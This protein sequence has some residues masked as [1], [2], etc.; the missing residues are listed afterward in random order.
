MTNAHSIEI[1]KGVTIAKGELY[2]WN[3]LQPSPLEK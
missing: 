1:E 2:L 3:F